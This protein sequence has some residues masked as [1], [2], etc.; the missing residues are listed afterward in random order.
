MSHVAFFLRGITK[1]VPTSFEFVGKQEQRVVIYGWS[2]GAI[3]FFSNEV[4]SRGAKRNTTEVRIVFYIV[5]GGPN[6]R[7]LPTFDACFY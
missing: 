2:L 3:N 6:N 1:T 4:P 5:N 7:Q